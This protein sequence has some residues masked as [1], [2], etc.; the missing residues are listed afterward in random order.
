MSKKKA[1]G[2]VRRARIAAKTVRSGR[3][4]WGGSGAR[5][6]GRSGKLKS[7]FAEADLETEIASR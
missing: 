6:L 5:R 1:F 2:S 4:V 7:P 3:K